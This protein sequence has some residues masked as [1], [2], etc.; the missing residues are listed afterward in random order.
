MQSIIVGV[1]GGDPS[2]L[3]A[4][5]AVA[6]AERTGAALHFVTA[7]RHSDVETIEA[8]GDH[9]IVSDV[10]IAEQH[11]R[12]FAASLGS[13]APITV[14]ALSGPPAKVILTEA[15]RLGVDLIVVGNRRMQGAGRVLGSVGTDVIKHAPC[16]VLVAKT[17]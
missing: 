6:L 2:K 10:D 9:W 17:T 13:S 11:V 1:D 15:E 16:N 3:A 4:R 8:G 12:D 7:V 14:S 5:E